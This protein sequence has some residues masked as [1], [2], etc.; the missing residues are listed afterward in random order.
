MQRPENY[1]L[2]AMLIFAGGVLMLA[3]AIACHI[4]GR[5][6][7]LHSRYL[8]LRVCAPPLVM[9]FVI[10]L[11]VIVPLALAGFYQSSYGYQLQLGE[12]SGPLGTMGDLIGVLLLLF[13][14]LLLLGYALVLFVYGTF[15]FYRWL[16]EEVPNQSS[17]DI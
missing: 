4:W 14:F 2:F 13:G 5:R 16:G 1:G 9:L 8:A 12:P 6:I 11:F 3:I 17:I 7:I 15:R 10:T